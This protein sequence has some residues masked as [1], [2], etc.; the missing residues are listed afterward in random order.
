MCAATEAGYLE[1]DGLEGKIKTGCPMTPLQTSRYCYHH[2]TRVSKQEVQQST[3]QNEE[4]GIVKVIISKKETRSGV[5]Y[6]VAKQ[7]RMCS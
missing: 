5:Y 4:E 6:Q 3:M 1:Y 2:A 7:L